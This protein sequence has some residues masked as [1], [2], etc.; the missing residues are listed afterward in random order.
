MRLLIV[1]DEPKAGDYLRKGLMES[2]FVTDLARTGPDGLNLAIEQ[3][4]DLILLD[5]MLPGIDGWEVLRQ[6]REKKETPVLFLTSRDEVSDRVKGLELGADDYLIKPFAFMELLA[7]VRTLLRRSPLREADT[8]SVGELEIDVL[9]RRVIRQGERI[10]LTAKEFALL[11][12]LVRRK[13]EVLSRSL[14]ASQVWDM[15]FDSDTNVVDVAMRRLRAKVDDRFDKKLVHT[16]RG[17]GYVFEE[18]D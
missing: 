14:I 15:N 10:E 3:N 11:H 5:V 4:Y 13:G 17:M 6:L 16:V 8:M 12:L 9:K 7:R 18:R 1:E 2:G